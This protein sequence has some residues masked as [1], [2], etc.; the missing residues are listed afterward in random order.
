MLF[1]LLAPVGIYLLVMV[2]LVLLSWRRPTLG[3]VNGTLRGCGTAPNC[4]SSLASDESHQVDAFAADGDTLQALLRL[5]EIL[6]SRPGMR[7]VTAKDDYLHVECTTPLMR[8]VDDL[9]VL[10][11][12]EQGVLHIR[13]AS[14]VGHSDLGANRHRVEEI[15]RLFQQ[16]SGEPGGDLREE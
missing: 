7:I 8:F 14:R 16:A 2:A 15:R 12:P 1:W 3:P 11:D 5:K 10:A 13:S 4:V 6:S 9:E